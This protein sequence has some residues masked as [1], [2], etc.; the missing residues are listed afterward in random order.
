M[1]TR[2]TKRILNVRNWK[3]DEDWEFGFRDNTFYYA[4]Y[5]EDAAERRQWIAEFTATHG[6]DVP[7]PAYLL[8]KADA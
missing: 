2:P 4:G 1:T 6:E 5:P 3:T 8:K 7:V